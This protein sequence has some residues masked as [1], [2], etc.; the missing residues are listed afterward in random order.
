M[1]S[2]I[3]MILFIG[4]IIIRIRA[5]R[6]KLFSWAEKSEY[7]IDSYTQQWFVWGSN[8]KLIGNQIVFLVSARKANELKTFYLIIGHWLWGMF[9]DQID[10][11]WETN[12]IG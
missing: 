10:I 5:A 11:D 8:R 12:I 6:S 9:E 2:F 1:F 3:V 7:R 4:W